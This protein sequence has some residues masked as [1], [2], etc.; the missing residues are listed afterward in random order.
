MQQ[1]YVIAGD[2]RNESR[3][4]G[5]LRVAVSPNDGQTSP[6]TIEQQRKYFTG[7]RFAL[8]EQD[9]FSTGRVSFC[10]FGWKQ[11]G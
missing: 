9:R 10:R 7:M 5:N 11:S 4:A 3:L 1:S 2:L 8:N 6:S